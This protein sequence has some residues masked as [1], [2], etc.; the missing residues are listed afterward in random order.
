MNVDEKYRNKGVSTGLIKEMCHYYRKQRLDK[1]V[2]L[3]VMVDNDKAKSLYEKL[4]F[5]EYPLPSSNGDGNIIMVAPIKDLYKNADN[6]LKS[7][8]KR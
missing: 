4:G 5:R 2:S 1:M 3:D 8:N 7:S 6:I